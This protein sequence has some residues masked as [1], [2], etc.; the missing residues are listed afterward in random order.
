MFRVSIS[1]NLMNSNWYALLVK[2]NK[3][4]LVAGGLEGKDIQCILPTYSVKRQWSDRS[5]AV[6]LPL[7]PGY[8]F[9][10]IP[11]GDES[12]RILTTPGVIRF[13]SF[14][15]QPTPIPENEIQMVRTLAE[16]N[17][18][19]EPW[20]YL[21]PGQRVRVERGPFKEWEGIVSRK[22]A[23]SHLIVHLHFLQRSVAVEL[24]QQDIRPF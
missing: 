7:F 3:E 9:C 5:R 17:Q 14:G 8:V 23:E 22:K 24:S 11:D 4:R 16:S 19:L 20:P 21:E 13:V 12:P 1:L 18:I 10:R 2:R 15:K 6:T